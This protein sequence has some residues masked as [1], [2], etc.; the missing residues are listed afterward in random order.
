MMKNLFVYKNQDITLDIIIKIEQ[1]ARLI[2]IETGKTFDDCL[3]D[4][5]LSKAYDM[6]RKTSSLM[7]AESAEFIADEFFRENPCQLKEKEDL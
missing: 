7:W 1:V 6:L 4:F 5:Y 3:Y 2:A